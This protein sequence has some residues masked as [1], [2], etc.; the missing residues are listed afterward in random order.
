[1]K[2][3]FCII[4]YV[5]L[6]IIKTMTFDS[7]WDM[8]VVKYCGEYWKPGHSQQDCLTMNHNSANTF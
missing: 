5:L 3:A 1:M 7:T 6:F 2:K 8:R 4:I